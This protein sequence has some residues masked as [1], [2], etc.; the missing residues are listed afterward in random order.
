MKLGIIMAMGTILG[1]EIGAQGIEILK[2]GAQVDLI[3]SVVF[4]VVLLLISAFMGWES[5][6]TLNS[7]Q[8]A[9]E[10]RGIQNPLARAD[11]SVFDYVPKKIYRIRLWPMISFP[12]SGIKRISV[13]IV[14]L[15]AVVGGIF[16]GFLGGG[17]GYVRMPALVYLLGVPTHVA[18]GTDLFEIIISAGY[19]TI[20]HSIK[21]NVDIIVALVMH[22]GAAVGAQIGVMLTKYFVGPWI[23]LT[24]FPLPLLGAA[25]IVYG[26]VTGHHFK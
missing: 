9:Q 2:Q 13:W 5:W 22:T 17:A 10:R 21:G 14:W 26:L 12:E 11:Q 1:I 20:T 25:L 7:R 8:C 6:K 15:V 18:V 3:V 24:F 4:I 23:R 16:S 19:G